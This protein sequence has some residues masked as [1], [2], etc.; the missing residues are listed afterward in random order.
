MR[1]F[2]LIK[3]F[4]KSICSAFQFYANSSVERLGKASGADG[5]AL[6]KGRAVRAERLEKSTCALEFK[7]TAAAPIAIAEAS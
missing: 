7:A 2:S 1:I 4:R 6:F 3:L 5:A